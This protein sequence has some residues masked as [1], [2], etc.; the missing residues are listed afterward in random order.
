M[1]NVVVKSVEA[2]REQRQF[3]QL[4]WQLHRDNPNWMPP[5]RTNRKELVGYRKHPFCEENEVHFRP[6]GRSTVRARGRHRQ[7]RAYSEV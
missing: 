2:R 5:L 7:S 4:P 3:L 1:S 6:E